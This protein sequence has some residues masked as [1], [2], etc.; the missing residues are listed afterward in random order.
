MR[1][2]DI[3][4]NEEKEVTNEMKGMIPYEEAEEETGETVNKMDEKNEE[5]EKVEEEDVEEEEECDY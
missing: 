1:I 4:V 3:E 2:I 5:D